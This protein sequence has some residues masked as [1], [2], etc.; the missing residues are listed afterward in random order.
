M[1]LVVSGKSWRSGI[2]SLIAY[3]T[4]YTLCILGRAIAYGH[5]IRGNGHDIDGIGSWCFVVSFGHGHAPDI[6]LDPKL[7][8]L[9]TTSSLSDQ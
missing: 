6:W 5:D 7:F 9:H 8:R 1:G 2:R 4:L 3:V